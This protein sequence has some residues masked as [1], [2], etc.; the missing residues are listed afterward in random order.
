MG[1][2]SWYVLNYRK[3]QYFVFTSS[4]KFGTLNTIIACTVLYGSVVI[5]EVELKIKLKRQDGIIIAR[6]GKTE[7]S[8]VIVSGKNI[9]EVLS[10]FLDALVSHHKAKLKVQHMEPDLKEEIDSDSVHNSPIVRPVDKF[11]IVVGEMVL[12]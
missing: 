9:D 11:E 4:V 1:G 7:L 10:K 3:I 5:M 8:N 12:Y 2:G 6:G